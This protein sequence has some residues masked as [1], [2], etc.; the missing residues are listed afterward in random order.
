M[1]P[2]R[3]ML[4]E[5]K[6]VT[7]DSQIDQYCARPT[8]PLFKTLTLLQFIQRYRIPKR[9]GDNLC[10]RRKDVAMTVHPY[11][12]SD[13]D[14]PMYE[15]YCKQRLMLCYQFCQL[16]EV[17]GIFQLHIPFSS[18]LAQFHLPLQKTFISLKLWGR[19][20]VP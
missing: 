1:D 16:E 12:S 20:R 18:S 4:D 8:I 15:Q 10:R 13:P 9:V 3:L 7:V 2:E 17:L 5:G 11:C 14:G 6:V 19:M